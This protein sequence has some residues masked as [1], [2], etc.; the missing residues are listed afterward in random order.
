[1]TE[2]NERPWGE[3]LQQ[4][5]EELGISLEQAEAETRIRMR[6]LKAL[7]SGDV[8]ALPDPVVGRGFLRNYAAYLGL[9]P[10][11]AQVRFSQLSP[12]PELES[13]P[14]ASEAS[15]FEGPFE[16]VPLHKMPSFLRR[17]RGVGVL[18]AAVLL[19]AAL[20]A[21]AWFGYPYLM[22]W[23]SP[24]NPTPQPTLA[25]TFTSQPPTATSLP[26]VVT[27]EP[28]SPE[29]TLAAA[30]TPT[31]EV[32]PPPTIRVSPSPPPTSPVYTGVFLELVFTDT[33]WIQVTVDG[34]RQFQGELAQDTYRS[35]Y[36][37]NRI[38]L[39]IGNAGVVLVTV[40]G[41]QLG[42]LGELG[43]VVDQVFEKVGDDVTEATVT[44][45]MTGTETVEPATEA[46]EA[47]TI[48]P[49]MVLTT[50]TVAPPT[51]TTAPP[52]PT[53][54]TTAPVTPTAGT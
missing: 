51:A 29:A 43:E 14:M 25:A 24:V 49:T 12:A 23:W 53:L 13:P 15:P 21:A 2:D 32:S 35:W 4:R 30:S 27:V 33:S 28:V 7:E 6:S 19:V 3:W 1:M 9:D 48:E 26:T 44:P 39:R 42:T 20:G 37:Q 22:Q 54:T 50:P 36:G 17:R 34:V 45:V 46:T 40:N 16:P 47:P 11:E 10:K 41:Q 5:R 52:A 18:L 38:E 31:L 8:D